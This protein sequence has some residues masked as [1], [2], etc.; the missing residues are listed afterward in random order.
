MWYVFPFASWLLPIFLP[1]LVHPWLYVLAGILHRDL[2]L[3]NT[4]YRITK[5]KNEAGV[6]EEKV[7]G[8]LTDFDLASWTNTL[9]QDYTKTSQQRTGTPPWPTGYSMDLTAST[10]IGMT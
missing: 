2:S 9:N 1:G 7:C 10:C 8:V 4:M 6:I 5:E 3:N